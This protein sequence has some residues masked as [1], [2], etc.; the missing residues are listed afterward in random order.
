MKKLLLL[1]IMGISTVSF[2][3]EIS[4]FD[5]DGDAVAYI[6][7]D[8][9]LTIYLWTGKPV[10]YLYSSSGKYHVYGFNGSHLGWFIDGVIRDH[11][12][13]AVGVT[14]DATSMY[15]NYEPYKG[16]KEYKPYKSYREYAPYQPYL[17]SSFSSTNFK[18]F[19]LQGL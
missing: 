2:S 14:K 6:D 5:K 3:Q 4:L 1:L 18:I 9:D 16:Y 10:C 8:D 11:D 7:T 12:G 15:T 17:S 13:D 19:L